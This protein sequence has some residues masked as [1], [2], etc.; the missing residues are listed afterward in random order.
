[1]TPLIP[2]ARRVHMGVCINQKKIMNKQFES[3][4]GL[5]VRSEDKSQ[6]RLETLVYV[7]LILTAVLS[8]VQF[9]VQ[10]RGLSTE[11]IVRKA[12]AAITAQGG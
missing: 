9:A 3:T 2:V 6:S 1:M 4:Y 12:T 7:V 10:T 5:I 11:R 8:I